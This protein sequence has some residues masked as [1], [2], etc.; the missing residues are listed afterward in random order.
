[1]RNLSTLA[2]PDYLARWKFAYP[3]DT[4]LLIEKHIRCIDTGQDYRGWP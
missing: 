4:N 2:A 3:E 1:M